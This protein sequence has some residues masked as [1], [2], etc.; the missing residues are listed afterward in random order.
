M[1]LIALLTVAVVAAVFGS[2][3]FATPTK[4]QEG[5]KKMLLH[6]VAFKYKETTTP[7]DIKRIED[8]FKAL[9]T[10][11]PGIVSFQHGTNNS[12]E[13]HA[14]GFTH[15]YILGFESEKARDEYLPHPEHKKF[16]GIV[17]PHLADVFVVDF[18]AN[19]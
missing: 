18:W 5:K 4:A 14:K 19:E 6:V 10:S 13:K 2:I 9:K 11:I 3:M 12:P 8:A 15:C 17:G 16:G 7:D 1:K